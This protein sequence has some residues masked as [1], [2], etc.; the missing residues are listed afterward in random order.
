MEIYF[1]ETIPVWNKIF[2]KSGLMLNILFQEKLFIFL[3][4]TLFNSQYQDCI[5]KMIQMHMYSAS[6]KMYSDG[7]QHIYH[8]KTKS[9]Y[10]DGVG[11]GIGRQ[12]YRTNQ[13]I[14]SLP[15]LMALTVVCSV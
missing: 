6:V 1:S 5:Y 4:I 10:P 14:C 11:E 9:Q 12:Q 13:K 2:E 3:G 15:S 8:Y 7:I